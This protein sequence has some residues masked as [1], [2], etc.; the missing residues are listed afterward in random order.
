MRL[1]RRESLRLV[2]GV[3]E[4]GLWPRPPLIAHAARAGVRFK[5]GVTDWN[6]KLE[7]KKK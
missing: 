7:N 6:L 1:S 2:G 3:A 5:V 4:A